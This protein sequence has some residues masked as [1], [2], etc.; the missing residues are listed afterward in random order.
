MVVA[1]WRPAV[2]LAV[3]PL[4]AARRLPLA[5]R[6]RGTLTSAVARVTGGRV[7]GDRGD[8]DRA[9]PSLGGPAYEGDRGAGVHTG[10]G[11]FERDRGGGGF[12]ATEFSRTAETYTPPPPAPWK[13][14]TTASSS[15]AAC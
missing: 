10:G 12:G 9:S 7:G 2:R 11:G 8:R 6:A 13:A 15:S 14:P 3:A 4:A 5:E 1:A